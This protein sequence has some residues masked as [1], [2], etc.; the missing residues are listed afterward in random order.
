VILYRYVK[1]V[2]TT[3]GVLFSGMAFGIGGKN[4]KRKR[5]GAVMG[6]VRNVD[7]YNHEAVGAN[8]KQVLVRG[9]SYTL[10]DDA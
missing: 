10:L 9:L 5:T 1:I 2:C 8:G 4:K 7:L 6:D 3:E